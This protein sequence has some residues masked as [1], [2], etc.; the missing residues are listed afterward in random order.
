MS[1]RE[2]TRADIC[3]L[4][5]AEC[6]RND[7]EI[8]V[9]AMG[10]TPSLGARLAKATFEPN[11]LMTDGYNLL[12]RRALPLGAT[13]TD[14]DIEGWMPFGS[15]FD[16]LWWGRRHVMMGASQIDQLGNQNIACIGPWQ[17]PKAQ[18]LGVRGAPGN[19]INHTTSYW[20]PN[21]DA[22]VFVPSVDMVSGVGYDRAASLD[23]SSSRFHEIRRVV[24]NLGVFDFNTPDHRMRLVSVHPGV[25]VDRVLASTGFELVVPD[26]LD[27][28]P[29]PTPDQLS[30]LRELDPQ[31]RAQKEVAA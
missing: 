5:I 26:R 10:T 15:V 21:H 29:V 6:F 20:V 8:L 4:A 11:L 7:G 28:T 30:A 12:L 14:D 19:T 22:R 2:A 25:E 18:L 1:V 9:S 31:G 17:H 16:T 23:D 27:T 13:P 3:A 24:T